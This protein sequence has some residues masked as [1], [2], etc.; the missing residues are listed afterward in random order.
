MFSYLKSVYNCINYYRQLQAMKGSWETFDP[1][2][3]SQNPL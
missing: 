1:N 2:W 3:K